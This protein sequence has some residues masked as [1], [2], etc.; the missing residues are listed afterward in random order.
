MKRREVVRSARPEVVAEN[1]A[2]RVPRGGP[3]PGHHHGPMESVREATYKGHRIVVRTTY[4][5]EVDGAPLAG[6]LGV[7]NDGQV[8]YHAIPNLGFASAVDVVKE[9]IDAFPDDFPPAADPAEGAGTV[10]GHTD[11]V[12]G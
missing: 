3:P 1:V 10:G 9:I 4:Q 11:H 6:H 5:I 2:R 8:H 12:H 7:T